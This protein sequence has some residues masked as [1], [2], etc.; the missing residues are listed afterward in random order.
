MNEKLMVFR[1][2]PS[3]VEAEALRSFFWEHG[4]DGGMKRDAFNPSCGW[5]RRT[6]AYRAQPYKVRLSY[7]GWSGPKSCF[8]GVKKL[9]TY[10]LPESWVS[11]EEEKGLALLDLWRQAFCSLV[12]EGTGSG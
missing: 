6:Y 8:L 7:V 5:V 12:S 9:D 10:L 3:P 1:G 4:R 11:E 2:T